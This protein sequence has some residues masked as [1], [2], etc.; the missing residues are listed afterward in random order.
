MLMN[1]MTIPWF[2]PMAATTVPIIV[3]LTTILW[4]L[5]AN[6]QFFCASKHGGI[7]VDRG[8]K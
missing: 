8:A 1:C 2:S 6:F 7:C 5:R 4:V 3:L